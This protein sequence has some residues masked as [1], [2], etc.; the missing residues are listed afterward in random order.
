MISEPTMVSVKYPYVYEDVDRHGNVRLYFW[1]KGQRKVRIRET[2]GTEAF[3]AH[4]EQLLHASEAGKLAHATHADRNTP[5][6]GTWRWLCIEYFG[7][8]TFRRLEP[9][10]QTTRRRILESTLD[11][12]I[13][14]GSPETFAAFP[15]S[16]MTSKALRVLRDRKANMPEAA[17]GRVKAIRAVFAW[18]LEQ[19]HVA[20][21]PARDVLRIKNASSGY[22]SW[23]PEEVEKFEKHH[24]IGSKP[25][26]ALALLTYTGVRRSDLVRLGKQHVRDGWLR[27]KQH[28]NRNR[29]PV[30]VEI[31]ILPELQRIVDASP[32][33]DLTYLVTAYGRPFTAAGFGIR[34]RE[35]C[36][37][38]GLPHCTAHG[39]RKAGA[40][41][42]A[43]NGASEHQLMAI[44][45][46]QTIKEAERYTKAARRKKMAGDAMPL[47]KRIKD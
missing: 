22:H 29:H 19:E 46:W 30:E 11:E 8:P 4:Y 6:P 2:P 43:E 12:P 33:G 31:P 38:A 32:T 14:P 37:K 47:L 42:A 18:A 23:T 16:R 44:F 24:P 5:T 41:I 34:F 9:T 1:R 20:A 10:T 28:K 40:A 21:N 7:S 39:L 45:G 27:F 17:N 26:L 15:L 13:H 3:A 25:R 36:D 35:W